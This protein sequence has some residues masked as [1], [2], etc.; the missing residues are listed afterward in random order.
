MRRQ[1]IWGGVGV[2]ALLLTGALVGM[3]VRVLSLELVIVDREGMRTVLGSLPNGAFA[4]RLSP[5]GTRVAFTRGGA[6]WIVDIPAL[7]EPRQVPARPDAQ[8]VAWDSSGERLFYT[9]STGTNQAIF[10]TDAD[11]TGGQGAPVRDPGRA[12]DSHSAALNAFSFITLS[13][14]DYDI[15]LFDETTRKTS[16]LVVITGSRQLSSAISPDGRWLAYK[17]DENGRFEI[18]VQPIDGGTRVQVTRG[19]GSNPV[20][21]GDGRE[22]FYDDGDGLFVVDVIGDA[23]L[24]FGQPRGLPVRGIEQSGS[25][26]RQWNVMPDGRFLVMVR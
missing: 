5:D 6:I 8:F 24:T 26:R 15:Y 20:W 16:P 3:A 17:S 9:A 7:G 23:E 14:G 22:I 12:P 10:V 4:P 2:V 21:S 1:V 18:W 13:G 11:G 19:G 25:L